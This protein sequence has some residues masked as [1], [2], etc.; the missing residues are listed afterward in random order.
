[1]DLADL[2]VKLETFCYNV[3]GYPPI[4]WNVNAAKW[5]VANGGTIALVDITPEMMRDVA[6]KNSWDEAHLANVD[7]SVPGIGAPFVWG[8]GIIYVL[9]DGIHRNARA[10]REGKGFKAH[11]LTDEAARRCLI[12]GPL[13]L[14]PWG[15][16]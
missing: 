9:I 7:P 10:L 14:M 12:E 2:H 8:G 11:L 4:R 3:P 5:A 13:A 1:M 16:R 15:Q 6:A